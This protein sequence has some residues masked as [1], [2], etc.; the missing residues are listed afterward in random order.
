MNYVP[1][2]SIFPDRR[3]ASLLRRD[4]SELTRVSCVLS[5][6]LHELRGGVVALGAMKFLHGGPPMGIRKKEVLH[7]E[8]ERVRRRFGWWRQPHEASPANLRAT[9]ERGCQSVLPRL[10][11]ATT[12]RLA[13]N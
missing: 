7:A 11:L 2:V 1:I 10:R 12:S 9:V 4:S 3:F 6:S 13:G 8:R 5:A